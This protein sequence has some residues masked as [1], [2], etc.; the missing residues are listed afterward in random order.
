MFLI[1]GIPAVQ[2]KLGKYATKKVNEEFKTDINIAKV[3]LQLNGD[4][5]LKNIFIKDHK[6]DTLISIGE[7]NSSIVSFKNLYDGKLNFGDIDI[8]DL[9]FNLKTYEGEED[10]NLDVFVEKFEDDNPREGPSK[11]LFSS[12]DISIEDGVFRLTDDNIETPKIL[13]FTQLNVNTT[14]FLISGPDVSCRI[15]KLGFKD[16]RGIVVDNLMA[17]FEYTLDH[18]N[19]GNLDIKTKNSELKGDLRFDYLR[20]D[21]KDFTDKVNV[22]A[23]F[24]DSQISL[25]E[26]N[27]FFNEFGV[28]Q[29]ASFNADLSGTLNKLAASNLN[30]STSRNTRIIGDITFEN[31]FR[32][33]DDSFA[34]EGKFKNLSSNYNDLTA[35]LPR[36]LGNAIPTVL[37][38]VG[39]F[40][41]NGTSR[42]TAKQI[43]A[44]IA[45]NTDLGDLKSNLELTEIDDIDEANYIGNV[46]FDQFDIGQLIDDPKAKYVSANVDVDGKGFTIDNLR[47]D[48][49]GDV[50]S[51]DYNDYTYEGIVISG[52]LG[53]KVFNGRLITE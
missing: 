28:N 3:G 38:K 47:T 9:V 50:Y 11:F 40:R 45:I 29:K 48:I 30:V 24:K 10:T 6:K 46:V 37:S 7:L 1:L 49:K 13:E 16:S 53:N 17:N 20:E 51:L 31:V 2:T 32:K 42:I 36:I 52:D 19:F 14:N 44:D 18:M 22:T 39:N 41:I 34:L 43:N 23:S 12:S 33:E 27:V 21:L 4:I 8:Q 26:L 15:N 5:E 35:L 25:T